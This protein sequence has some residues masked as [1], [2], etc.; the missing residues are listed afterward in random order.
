MQVPAPGLDATSAFIALQAVNIMP[1]M[2][3]P[4]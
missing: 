4:E 2:L 3:I 1:E